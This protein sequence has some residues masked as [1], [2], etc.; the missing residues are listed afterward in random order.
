LD[1]QPEQARPALTTIKAAS[2]DALH[3]LRGALDLLRSGDGA[4]L[5]PAPR[6]TDLDTLVEGVRHAGLTVRLE[7]TVTDTALPATVEVAAYRIVQEALTNVTRHAGARAVD[8]RVG[9]DG[10]GG[11]VTV[12]VTDDGVGGAVGAAVVAGNG[13]TGM[14]ERAAAVGGTVTVGP[15]PGGGFRVLAHLPG[16]AA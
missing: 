4:P 6:L 3:E 8:V 9:S 2:R 1:E 11:G 5:A 10:P 12:E 14:R 15:V 16:P 13:I 7:C